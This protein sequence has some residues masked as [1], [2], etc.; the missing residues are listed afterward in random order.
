MTKFRAAVLAKFPDARAKRAWPPVDGFSG[1]IIARLD[2]TQLGCS[3]S[4]SSAAAWRNACRLIEARERA[5]IEL[6]K[7]NGFD[8]PTAERV[9]QELIAE[10]EDRM[11]NGTSKNPD[12]PRGLLRF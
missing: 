10:L 6:M 8:R 1:W 5:I 4:G 11:I 2:G 7:L 12:P 9:H 3:Y